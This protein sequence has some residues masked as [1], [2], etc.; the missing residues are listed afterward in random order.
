MKQ[1]YFLSFAYDGTPFSGWQRQINAISVQQILE[2]AIA[3]LAQE[4]IP[5]TG[6][7]RTD[8]GV[9]ASRYIAHADLPAEA[10]QDW[11][12][13]LNGLLPMAIRVRGLH[14]VHPEA[15]ARFDAVQ[16][17]Y[18]YRLHRVHNPFERA[19]SYRYPF[20]P[21]DLSAMNAAAA[22]LCEA[23][24]F[25]TFQKTGS[26]AKTATCRIDFAFWEPDPHCPPEAEGWVFRIGANRFLRGMVR[27][28]VGALLEVGRGRL[29]P[30]TF[31]QT[32]ATGERFPRTTAAPAHGLYL[33]RIM[34][35]YDVGPV[36]GQNSAQQ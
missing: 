24:D 28:I 5:V 12:E 31:Q 33:H 30:L 8:T 4:P 34:Y 22:T 16:R 13:R 21:W 27:L 26:D 7:G 32:V 6:C 20:G 15:H 3:V 29:D 2:E 1:R 14:P 10:T 19:W 17:S 25:S 11:I 9:H 23:N 18:A 36:K 35:P